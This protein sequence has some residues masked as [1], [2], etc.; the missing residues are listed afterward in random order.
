MVFKGRQYNKPPKRIRS[1]SD[2]F[3]FLEYR[4]LEDHM[5]TLVLSQQ[6]YRLYIRGVSSFHSY[7]LSFINVN[8]SGHVN[9]GEQNLVAADHL[10]LSLNLCRAGITISHLKGSS[11]LGV[12]VISPFCRFT[13]F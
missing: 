11:G 3:I 5:D 8:C 10:A 12:Y 6:R 13:L 4:R 2:M 9:I 1:L 7:S